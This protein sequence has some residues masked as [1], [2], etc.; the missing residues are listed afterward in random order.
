MFH[1]SES[2]YITLEDKSATGKKR[3]WKGKKLRSSLMA[4]HYEGLEKR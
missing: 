1:S 3:D 2:N 4:S